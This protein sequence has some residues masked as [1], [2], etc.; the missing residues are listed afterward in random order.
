MVWWKAASCMFACTLESQSF[1]DV[2]ILC[3]LNRHLYS[4]CEGWNKISFL[5]WEWRKNYIL[6]GETFDT[7]G[8]SH[9]YI[10]NSFYQPDMPTLGFLFPQISYP[11]NRPHAYRRHRTLHKSQYSCTVQRLSIFFLTARESSFPGLC[12]SIIFESGSST[13]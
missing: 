1:M 4:F 2:V 12:M 7:L 8:R 6:E 10:S 13:C 5:L 9:S 3:P 11:H